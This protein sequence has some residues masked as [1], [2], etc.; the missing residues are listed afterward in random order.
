[1]FIQSIFCFVGLELPSPLN[2][3]GIRRDGT[4]ASD[5]KAPHE[6]AALQQVVLHKQRRV[7]RRQERIGDRSVWLEVV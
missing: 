2:T 3:V 5:G 4:D 6:A 7:I 1:M